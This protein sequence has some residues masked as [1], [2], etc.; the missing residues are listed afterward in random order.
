M[1]VSRNILSCNQ[2]VY[3]WDLNEFQVTFDVFNFSEIIEMERRAN[4]ILNGRKRSTILSTSNS[5]KQKSN[6]TTTSELRKTKYTF[7]LLRKSISQ[8]SDMT[9]EYDDFN[10]QGKQSKSQPKM[11]Q[12]LISE[13]EIDGLRNPSMLPAQTSQAATNSGISI[14]SGMISNAGK[15]YTLVL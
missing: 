4:A 10:E 11:N 13:N 14:T 15:N 12:S 9:K 2:N 8:D 1:Q 5:S 6:E 7:S 3:N